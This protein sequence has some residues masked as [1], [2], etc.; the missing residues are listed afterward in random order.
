LE[1]EKE[2]LADKKTLLEEGLTYDNYV[3]RVTSDKMLVLLETPLVTRG[4]KR[5]FFKN[6]PKIK[7]FLISQGIQFVS[8]EPEE[9]DGKFIV[10]KGH[11][12]REGH[13]ERIEFLPK[14]E[15]LI[16]K[17]EED[18]IKEIPEDEGKA[19]DLREKV[20]K[21]L[22]VKEGEA[23]AKW[24]PLTP[25]TPGINV[26]G[27]E[28]QPPPLKEEKTFE[29]SDNV[30]LDEKERLIKAKISGVV[31]FEKGKIDVLPEYVLKG[32]VDFSVG[33]IYFYGKKLTI[34]GDV[35]FGFKVIVE[36]DLELRGCTENKVKIEVKG[37]LLADGVI[38]GEHTT[39]E[40]WGEAKIR[41]AE[42]AKILVHENLY[43]KDY[44]VFTD[45]LAEGDL[46]AIEG[47]GL[48]YGGEVRAIGD[49]EVKMVG[50]A[51]QTLTIIEAGYPPDI[52]EDYLVTTERIKIL[53][54][55]L[56]KIDDGLKLASKLK[57]EGRLT[58]EKLK[59][60]EKLINER[61]RITEEI[62]KL[63]PMLKDLSTKLTE[64]RKKTI[65][66][67]QKI[68][69]NVTLRIAEFTYTNNEE[70]NGPIVFYLDVT[71]IKYREGGK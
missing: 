25:P 28:V 2:E 16:K 40:V 34:Q 26:F 66:I 70:L 46:K 71:E 7:E 4:D 27:E 30:Y 36:G 23:I 54:E 29:L 21:I 56:T 53:N 19:E 43:V 10:A 48:I 1:L 20:Q 49:V 59:Y 69:P 42:F 62:A 17:T 24:H 39:V 55:F 45:T 3:F 44:L 65:R 33:N 60:V 58:E 64:Y 38:R 8:E 47:K 57:E 13:P 22:C 51:A 12:P 11:L 14:F 63:E 32:D 50:H 37:N 68:F 52:V 6:Y 9:L 67:Q 18:L 61:K 41:G 5:R 35:K 15:R 31:T